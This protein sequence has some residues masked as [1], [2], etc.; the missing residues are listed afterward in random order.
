LRQARRQIAFLLNLRNQYIFITIIE[1][2]FDQVEGE[3]KIQVMAKK[4]A[5]INRGIFNLTVILKHEI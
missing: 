1:K 5:G 4:G 3:K 2:I